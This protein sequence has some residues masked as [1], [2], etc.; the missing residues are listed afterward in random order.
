M[1]QGRS[2]R[3]AVT[4]LVPAGMV[5]ALATS[6]CGGGASSPEAGDAGGDRSFPGDAGQGED[7]IIVVVDSTAPDVV[8]HDG[9]DAGGDVVVVEAEA[10]VACDAATAIVCSGSCVDKETD[11]DNCNGCGIQCPGPEAGTGKGVCV[12]AACGLSCESDGGTSLLCPNGDCVDP[13]TISNCGACGTVCPAPTANGTASCGGSPLACGFSCTAGYHAA[14]GGAA[15]NV[16]CSPNTDDPSGDPCVVADGLGIFVSPSGSDTAAGTKEAPFQ[17]VGHAMDVAETTSK[18]VYACGTFTQ[19]QLVVGASRDGVTVYGGFSCAN[20][21][22]SASTQTKMSPVAQGYALAVNGTTTGVT[23]EDFEF[24]A[25]SAPNSPSLTPQSSIA[26]FANGARVTVTAGAGQPGAGGAAGGNYS[27]TAPGGNGPST[28]TTG[29][30]GGGPN[31]CGDNTSSTGGKGADVG[32]FATGGSP[33]P[34]NSG[35]SGTSSCTPGGV[36]APGTA[37]TTPAPG[38]TLTGSAGSSGWT[39]AASGGNGTNGNIGQGGGGG[40]SN[41]DVHG[42]PGGGGGAGGCGGGA[43]LGGTGGGASIGILSYQ[44]TVVTTATTIASAAGGPGGS[45]GLGQAGEAGGSGGAGAQTGDCVAG[46]GGGAGGI[47]GA[48]GGG[49]GGGGGAGGPSAGIVWKGGS[50]PSIDG[51]PVSSAATLAVITLGTQG[52]GGTGGLGGTGTGAAGAGGG[53]GVTPTAMA[54]FQSP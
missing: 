37:A 54:V 27:G 16:T 29:G 40:G 30:T 23:F 11:P 2:V 51:N 42:G 18:R 7:A 28:I 45:G 35:T 25:Q 14:G 8:E 22:Y 49:G 44:A 3:G 9:G 50:A 12:N 21:A 43:G 46:M 26:V 47:G 17:T 38:G 1:G 36:G 31:S 39:A 10:G 32:G 4:L 5:C 13:T 19:E 15:C 41:G 52:A 24:D 33:G 53:N 48:G 20:W 34:D 6:H